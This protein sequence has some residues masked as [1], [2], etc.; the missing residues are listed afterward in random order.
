MG[1]FVGGCCWLGASLPMLARGSWVG[2]RQNQHP[3]R[4]VSWGLYVH[5]STF[6]IHIS[7]LEGGGHVEVVV[8]GVLEV[9]ICF[10]HL[11]HGWLLC[12]LTRFGLGC[13]CFHKHLVDVSGYR[14]I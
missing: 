10:V 4:Q 7:Y 6:G 14:F 8:S 3:V 5:L 9:F 1:R 13:A 12:T 2:L 11:Y